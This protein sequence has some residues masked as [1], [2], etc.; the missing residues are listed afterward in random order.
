MWAGGYQENYN[1]N[2]IQITA[3]SS[4]ARTYSADASWNA[5]PWVSVDASYSKLHLDTIGG[6]NF[7][8][9]APVTT[10][11]TGQ[12]SL[13]ISNIHAANLGLRFAIR[14]YADLYV[15]YNITKD[16]GDDRS[17]ASSTAGTFATAI[18]GRGCA[19]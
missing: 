8:V 2:S 11:V 15:G 16:T 9:A 4:H 18:C 6:I 7:F 3:Y 1:N 17:T 14:K 13:Y 5:K 12:E 10:E 19:L